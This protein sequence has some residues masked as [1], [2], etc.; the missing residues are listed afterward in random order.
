MGVAVTQMIGPTFSGCIDG[1]Y[2]WQANFYLIAGS[3]FLVLD[4]FIFLVLG[5][6]YYDQ[7]ETLQKQGEELF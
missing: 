6:F 5:C 7:A 4:F 1:I 3:A 2:G